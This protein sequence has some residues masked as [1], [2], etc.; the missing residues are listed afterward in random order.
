MPSAAPIPRGPSVLLLGSPAGLLGRP[1]C[2]ACW[3]TAETGDAYLSWFALEGHG[4]ADMITRVCASRGMCAS[5]TRRLLDQPGAAARL[6]AVYRYVVRAAIGDLGAEPAPCPACEQ[7]SAAR[8]R[9]L[10][11]LLEGLCEADRRAYEQHGGL[12][13]PHLRR[14]VLTAAHGDVRWLVR[15]MASRLSDAR[16]GMDVL[17]G[18]PD[19]D[20][21]ARAGHRGALARRLSPGQPWTCSVCWAAASWERT[22]L[23]DLAAAS[24]ASAARDVLCS[25]HLRDLVLLA[26]AADDLLGCHAAA[27]RERLGQVLDGKPRLLGIAPG[28]LSVRARRVLAEPDCAVCHGMRTAAGRATGQI[29]AGRSE[30]MPAAFRLCVRHIRGLRAVDPVA[31][32]LASEAAREYGAALLTELDEAVGKRTQAPTVGGSG[33]ARGNAWRQAAAFL[34]GAVFGGCPAS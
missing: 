24:P 34:D 10:G 12:C 19:P 28:W 15:F 14:A 4:D 26:P 22:S 33:H 13:L 1:G 5:H 3:Y 16:P 6:T 31:R 27:Q 20:A 21:Q 29:A 25:M 7:L 8:D 23:A 17:A 9:V 11:L 18:G 32:H 30:L 2:P